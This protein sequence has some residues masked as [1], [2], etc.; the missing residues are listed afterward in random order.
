MKI[1]YL[2][3]GIV[4]KIKEINMKHCCV[5]VSK[6][7]QFARFACIMKNHNI[8]DSTLNT[9]H[10]TLKKKKNRNRVVKLKQRT[11]SGSIKSNII[12]EFINQNVSVFL[13]ET[14]FKRLTT[15]YSNLFSAALVASVKQTEKRKKKK[16]SNVYETHISALDVIQQQWV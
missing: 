8:L 12:L 1:K 6:I 7:E 9:L 3:S 10:K 2:S 5:C 14:F 4:Q 16:K 15:D 11:G 13:F